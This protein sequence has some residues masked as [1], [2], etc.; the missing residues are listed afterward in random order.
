MIDTLAGPYRSKELAFCDLVMAMEYNVLAPIQRGELSFQDTP[1]PSGT[2]EAIEDMDFVLVLADEFLAATDDI[3]NAQPDNMMI[4][5]ILA[6][7]REKPQDFDALIEIIG[8]AMRATTRVRYCNAAYEH[9]MRAFALLDALIE[10]YDIAFDLFP[11]PY[12]LD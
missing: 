4:R 6:V 11:T 5:Q 10:Q 2:R 12:P 1:L 8:K 7:I 3:A 9:I